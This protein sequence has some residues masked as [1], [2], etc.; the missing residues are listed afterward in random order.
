MTV[1]AVVGLALVGGAAGSAIAFEHRLSPSAAR[2]LRAKTAWLHI[3]FAWPIP[4]LL[5]F[6]V[7]K[8]Y[9]F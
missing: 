4:V 7:I 1:A 6:H 3:V 5:A 9:Y 8:T 2:R